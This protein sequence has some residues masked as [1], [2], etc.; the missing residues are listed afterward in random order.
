MKPKCCLKNEIEKPI[1]VCSYEELFSILGKKW[2]VLILRIIHIFG[3]SGYNEIFNK[4]SGITPKAF[5][6]KLRILENSGLIE[7]KVV[8]EQPLR[9]E[10]SLSFEGEK[11]LASLGP[12]FDE[13]L[14][15]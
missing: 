2:V 5:G 7:R 6:D 14:K 13:V 11:L 12:F 10:Y 15:L 3:S 8:S 4:I 9:T 1:C